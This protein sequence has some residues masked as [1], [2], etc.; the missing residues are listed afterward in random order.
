MG[1]RQLD[2]AVSLLPLSFLF[3]ICVLYYYY[4]Y[5]WYCY[6]VFQMFF[7]V[8]VHFYDTTI[9]IKIKIKKIKNNKDFISRGHSFDID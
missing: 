8:N 7:Y 1:L 5:N 2:L 6:Y 4:C 9:I 3:W